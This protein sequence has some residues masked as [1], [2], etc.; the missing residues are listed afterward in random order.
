MKTWNVW[1]EGRH[2]GTV[3]E[4]DEANAGCAALSKYGLDHEEWAAMTGEQQSASLG[5]V[6]PPDAEGIWVSPA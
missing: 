1:C 3:E 2:I 4:V 6:I 5:R